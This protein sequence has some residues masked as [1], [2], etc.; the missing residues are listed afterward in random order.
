[1][2]SVPA[3]LV[4]ASPLVSHGPSAETLFVR[5]S[6]SLF[7]SSDAV[8]KDGQVLGVDALVNCRSVETSVGRLL[9]LLL[10]C[11]RQHGPSNMPDRSLSN[12]TPGA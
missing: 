4:L 11:V 5:Q 1:M 3:E 10:A 8:V 7:G 12:E 6:G 2:R 9:W